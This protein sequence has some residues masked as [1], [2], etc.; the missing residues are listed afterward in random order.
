MSAVLLFFEDPQTANLKNCALPDGELNGSV[1]A[2]A[3]R[4][5]P[6][7]HE[8][9]AVF[10]NLIDLVSMLPDEKMHPIWDAFTATVLRLVY[11]R[12]LRFRE[13]CGSPVASKIA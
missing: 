12:W 2:L 6:F 11:R 3:R 1:D 9:I 13:G 7:D 4:I 10:K 8:A 5:A